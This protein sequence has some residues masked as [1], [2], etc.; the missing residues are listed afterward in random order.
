[1]SGASALE[2]IM[3]IN[4]LDGQRLAEFWHDKVTSQ[5]MAVSAGGRATD[6]FVDQLAA[7]ADSTVMGTSPSRRRTCSM[8][9]AVWRM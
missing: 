8:R 3:F 5:S 1:L 2:S 7:V 4:F 9:W 6:D